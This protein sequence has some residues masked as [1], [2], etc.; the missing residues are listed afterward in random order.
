MELACRG[1]RGGS[2][3][4]EAKVDR[5][6]RDD[7]AVVDA[8]VGGQSF[9]VQEGAVGGAQVVDHEPAA[10]TVDL[11]VMAAGVAVVDDDPAIGQTAD[12][13]APVAELDPVA[14]RHHDR[15][16]P[17][18]RLALLDL[19]R[20]AEPARLERVVDTQVDGDRAHEVVA[21]L[22]GVLANGLDELGAQRVLDVGEAGV[23]V[24]GEQDL[25]IVGHDPL[26]LDVD[27]AVIVHLADEAAPE[28]DRPD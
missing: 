7:V 18:A 3:G 5:A 22:A 26:A 2:G 20:D 25:E 24:G 13:V 12:Q 11:G 9:A 1:D 16:R 21:L 15:A 6:D 23:V 10:R 14:G 27:G 28:L 8:A 19:G 4:L 17:P